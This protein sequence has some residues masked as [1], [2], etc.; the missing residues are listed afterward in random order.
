MT[1]HLSLA[2][3]PTFKRDLKSVVSKRKWN[4]ADLESVLD[5]IADNTSESLEILKRRHGMHKLAGKWK[6]RNECHVANAGNWLLV[7]RVQDD[8]AF[9]ERTGTH[10]EIFRH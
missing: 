8:Y 7:W 10:D 6:G 9:I 2:F 1:K 5:L 4:L 3:T